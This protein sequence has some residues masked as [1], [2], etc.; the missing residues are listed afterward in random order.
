MCRKKYLKQ[1]IIFALKFLL[2]NF[3]PLHTNVRTCNVVRMKSIDQKII[4]Q[5]NYF[6]PASTG[7]AV[8]G[9]F[10]NPK[11][12]KKC[13]IFFTLLLLIFYKLKRNFYL[14]KLQKEFSF[15]FNS[16]SPLDRCQQQNEAKKKFHM[17]KLRQ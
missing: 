15:A 5:Y 2:F 8:L 4:W 13:L 14:T 17:F 9:F 12:T 1:L 7:C 10:G 6:F 11:I 16:F 3:V